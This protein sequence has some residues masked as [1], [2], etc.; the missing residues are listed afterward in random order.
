M[1]IYP[2]RIAYR[3]KRTSIW[4]YRSCTSTKKQKSE[5]LIHQ[6]VILKRTMINRLSQLHLPNLPQRP[7]RRPNPRSPTI[8]PCQAAASKPANPHRHII[9]LYTPI[10]ITDP[11][12]RLDAALVRPGKAHPRRARQGGEQDRVIDR[13]RKLVLKFPE[14]GAFSSCVPLQARGYI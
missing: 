10:I 8:L 6:K 14:L 4:R 5:N 9:H 12:P 1:Q 7:P 2:P 11:N 13:T 3:Q